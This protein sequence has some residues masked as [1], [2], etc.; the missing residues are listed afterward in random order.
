MTLG[1][2]LHHGFE[3]PA[4]HGNATLE[5]LKGLTA[6]VA[7]ARPH[8]SVHTIAELVAHMISWRRFA[9]QMLERNFEYR[10][11]IDSTIDWPDV[12]TLSQS[13]WEVLI[14]ELVHSQ[15]RIL[16]LLSSWTTEELNAPAGDRPF[17]V[18][19]I[20][21]GVADHDI[22]HGGQIAL[23]LKMKK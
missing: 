21:H 11:Q 9:I 19:V 8:P 6:D 5:L 3:G 13:E 23:T 7:T 10:I 4:W 20:V 17:S 14:Q 12:S 16:K 2:R 18:A 22:Y 1:E 15:S